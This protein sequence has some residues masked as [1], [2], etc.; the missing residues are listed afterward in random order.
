MSGAST[1]RNAVKRVTHK[2]R[3]QPSHRKKFGLL[4][5]KQDY[6]E[7]SY[8]YHKKSNYLKILK[9]KAKEKNPDEFYHNMHNSKISG[10]VHK[11]T[12]RLEVL[13]PE[14]LKLMKTQDL[15]YI[16]YRK[17]IDD[18]KIEKIRASL[19]FTAKGEKGSHKLF[20]EKDCLSEEGIEVDEENDV[21]GSENVDNDKDGNVNSFSNI[22]DF[23][24]KEV[25]KFKRS[26]E[27]SYGELERRIVRSRKLK[28]AVEGL[29]LQ[30]NL[31]NSKG[32]KR[33]VVNTEDPSK[34][35]YKW[36]RQRAK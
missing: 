31:S 14:T 10:G 36:K 19:H 22:G 26:Q 17:A 5:K 27:R 1:M 7:R 21:D 11:S 12:N 8:D 29:T 24:K 4:E 20:R 28:S 35:V 2:E 3:S 23:S 30:R 34:V 15:G 16:T 33:K 6:K 13:D 25:M 9:R 18:K 32:T